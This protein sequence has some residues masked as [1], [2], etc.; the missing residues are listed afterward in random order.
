VEESVSYSTGEEGVLT[1]VELAEAGNTLPVTHLV[2]TLKYRGIAYRR[3][4]CDDDEKVI[5][6]LFE[7]LK[8]CIGWDVS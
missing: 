7:V 5:P 2:L 1:N 3:C 4:C 6:R 8:G